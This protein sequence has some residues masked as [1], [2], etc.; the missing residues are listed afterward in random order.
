M[1]Q[2]S[3]IS[4]LVLALLLTACTAPTTTPP[5]VVTENPFIPAP[6]I[7]SLGEYPNPVTVEPTTN[8]YPPAYTPASPSSM[9][10]APGTPTTGSVAIPLSSFEPQS[11]DASLKRDQVFL[12]LPNSQLLVTIGE[13]VQVDAVLKGNLPDQC[14]SL[15]VVVTPPGTDNMINLD[16]YTVVDVRIAC[17]TMLEPFAATIPLGNYTSGI[18]TVMV[19]KTRLGQFAGAYAPTPEDDKLTRADVNVDM[20]ESQL[21]SLGLPIGDAAS[22]QGNLPDPCHALRIVLTPADSQ[23]KIDL[24]VY[25]VY[26]PQTMCIQVIAPFQVVVSLGNNPAGHYSVYV[27]GQLLGEFDK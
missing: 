17:T 2:K 1:T 16:V 8:P 6:T 15:R 9:Y 7:T 14:H 27:N 23:N 26:D 25:S 11:G 5:V 4:L 22:L 10:P 12:D 24:E 13:P 20:A 18:Y 19:N 3:I 21:V